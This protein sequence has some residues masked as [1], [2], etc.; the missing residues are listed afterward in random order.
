VFR[1]H[2]TSALA[3]CGVHADRV[4]SLRLFDGRSSWR[5]WR[6]WPRR[7]AGACGRARRCESLRYSE[8]AFERELRRGPPARGGMRS[9][10]EAGASHI[11]WSGAVAEE[12]QPRR[13]ARLAH[14]QRGRAAAGHHPA[15]ASCTT[16]RPVR[17]RSRAWTPRTRGVAHALRALSRMAWS[18]PTAS[19]SCA[20]A[21]AAARALRARA[22]PSACARGLSAPAMDEALLSALAAGLPAVSRG[23]RWASI[24]C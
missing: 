11:D 8:A 5:R 15:C 13:A 17:P 14:G 2:E 10:R 16:T 18:S 21:A 9:L 22:A 6:S 24:G 23:S 4:V 19:R 12:L 20:N 1:G 3:Q 7:A